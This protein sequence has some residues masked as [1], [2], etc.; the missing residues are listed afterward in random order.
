MEAFTKRIAV[1]FNSSSYNL[2]RKYVLLGPAH[3]IIPGTNLLLSD[4]EKI[5][6]AC[7]FKLQSQIAQSAD[8]SQRKTDILE[9]KMRGH[10]KL[11]LMSVKPSNFVHYVYLISWTNLS[12]KPL[13]TIILTFNKF[14]LSPLCGWAAKIFYFVRTTAEI[15]TTFTVSCYLNILIASSFSVVRLPDRRA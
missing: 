7:R 14:C 1:H 4:C 12:N 13:K 11:H 9:R 5:P 10:F 15:I 3:H 6:V 8:G 2:L